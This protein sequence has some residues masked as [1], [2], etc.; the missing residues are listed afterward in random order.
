RAQLFATAGSDDS[1][2][3]LFFAVSSTLHAVAF[4]GLVF[5]TTLSV[6]PVATALREDAPR[7][8]TQLVFVAT[9]GPGGGGGGGGLL[10]PAPAPKALRQGKKLTSSPVPARQPPKPIAPPVRPNLPE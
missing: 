1:R 8:E 9:P 7:E 5:L 2:L 4:S 6:V 10:Q 3:P